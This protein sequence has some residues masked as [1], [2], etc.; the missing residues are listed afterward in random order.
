MTDQCDIDE[1]VC[2]A[3]L[4][5]LGYIV[6]MPRKIT[7]YQACMALRIHPAH[8]ADPMTVRKVFKD[9]AYSCKGTTGTQ[10]R[11]ELL[12]KLRSQIEDFES[13]YKG[14]EWVDGHLKHTHDT[15]RRIEAGL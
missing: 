12:Q 6:D 7:E 10:Y 14:E 13:R 5:E 3:F 11:T 4:E 8:G 1:G 9:A 15:I 2:K